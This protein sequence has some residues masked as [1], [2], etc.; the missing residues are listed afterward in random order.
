M[1]SDIRDPWAWVVALTP[2]VKRVDRLNAGDPN[3]FVVKKDLARAVLRELHLDPSAD[4]F[5]GDFV[6]DAVDRKGAVL[7]DGSF[8]RY[9]KVLIKRLFGHQLARETPDGDLIP[10]NRPGLD[11]MMVAVVVFVPDPG[12]KGFIQSF[13]V[14]RSIGLMIRE[15]SL[16]D[17]SEKPFYLAP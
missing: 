13:Q 4:V 10:I 3:S 5:C 17:G 8:D 2:V 12:T 16:P 14:Q 7:V 15:K 11:P 6:K 1:Q 9:E